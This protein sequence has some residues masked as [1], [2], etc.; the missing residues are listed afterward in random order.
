MLAIAA[1]LPWLVRFYDGGY[2]VATGRQTD[3]VHILRG[4]VYALAFDESISV[5]PTF[6]PAYLLRNQAE[7]PS[8]WKDLQLAMKLLEEARRDP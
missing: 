8:A 1:V 3:L 7:K 6:H 5:V 2:P 4:R